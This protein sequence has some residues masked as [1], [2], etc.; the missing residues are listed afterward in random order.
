MTWKRGPAED[1]HHLALDHK[2]LRTTAMA[3]AVAATTDRLALAHLP[4]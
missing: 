2:I 1:G 4:Q 3:T